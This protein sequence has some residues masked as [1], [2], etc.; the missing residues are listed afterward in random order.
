[1]GRGHFLEA[2][3][4]LPIFLSNLPLPDAR[5]K[6]VTM[7]LGYFNQFHSCRKIFGIKEL[8]RI[9]NDSCPWD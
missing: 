8:I 7:H 9:L 4:K 6:F 1:M 3:C 2:E 5:M